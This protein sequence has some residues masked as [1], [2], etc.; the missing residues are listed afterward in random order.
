MGKRLREIKKKIFAVSI[1]IVGGIALV[2]YL[3]NYPD[4]KFS[5]FIWRILK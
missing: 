5:K 2:S 4:S 1:G 3:E